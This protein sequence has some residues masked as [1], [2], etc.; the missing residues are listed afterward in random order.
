VEEGRGGSFV[1]FV[2]FLQSK[3]KSGDE[4]RF[5]VFST[6]QLPDQAHCVPSDSFS[7]RTEGLVSGM[8]RLSVGSCVQVSALLQKLVFGTLWPSF[9][10][11]MRC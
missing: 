10:M 3:N 11:P 9:H 4:N 7:N 1:Y 6:D 5:G 2:G 8:Y